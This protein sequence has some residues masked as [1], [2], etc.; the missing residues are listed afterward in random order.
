MRPASLLK[1]GSIILV[2]TVV[3]EVGC[4]SIIANDPQQ[5]KFS[6]AILIMLTFPLAVLFGALGLA[7][8]LASGC[9]AVYRTLRRS[10]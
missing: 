9:L 5:T 4:L 3:L 2:S 6:G 1:I 8:V 10:N 7:L